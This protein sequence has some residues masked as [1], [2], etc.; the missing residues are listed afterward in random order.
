MRVAKWLI[1]HGISAEPAIRKAKVNPV[2]A[3]ILHRFRLAG[4]L[5]RALRR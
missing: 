2:A 4:S 1:L 3:K 5:R